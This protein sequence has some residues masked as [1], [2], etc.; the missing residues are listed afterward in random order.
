[1]N[2][3]VTHKLP[4]YVL[5]KEPISPDTLNIV[6]YLHAQG[7]DARPASIV[8]RD[9]PQECRQLPTIYDTKGREWYVGLE[10]CLYFFEKFTGLRWIHVE[11]TL[12]A[13]RM[14]SHSIS[15]E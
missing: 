11:A 5:Y 12:F 6:R 3:R 1:M 2:P 8:E 13:D 7:I 14:L 4:H 9:H 15:V 10:S